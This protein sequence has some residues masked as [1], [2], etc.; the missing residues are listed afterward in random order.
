M[1]SGYH[2]RLLNWM[3][4]GNHGNMGQRITRRAHTGSENRTVHQQPQLIFSERLVVVFI[5]RIDLEWD[6]KGIGPPCPVEVA[7]LFSTGK[8]RPKE[9]QRLVDGRCTTSVSESLVI[10]EPIAGSLRR[11]LFVVAQIALHEF[12]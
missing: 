5:C 9:S 8:H 7:V 6:I 12:R 4:N 3:I 1:S 2:A 11:S 10:F